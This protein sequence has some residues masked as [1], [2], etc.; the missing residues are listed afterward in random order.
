MSATEILEQFRALPPEEQRLVAERI[1]E[2]YEPD[3]ETPEMT[4]ELERRA[5]EFQKDPRQGIPWDEVRRELREK[6][7]WP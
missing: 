2:E 6:Y 1:W 3:F 7:G 5:A 4:A